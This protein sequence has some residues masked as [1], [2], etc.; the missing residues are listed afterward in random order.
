ML[1]LTFVLV[2]TAI[3]DYLS[4]YLVDNQKCWFLKER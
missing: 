3:S 1:G 4:S 2:L